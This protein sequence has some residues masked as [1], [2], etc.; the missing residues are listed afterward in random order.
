[1]CLI[2]MTLSVT[3]FGGIS[4]H[5]AT[6]DNG[7]ILYCPCMGLNLMYTLSI[8][9]IYFNLLGPTCLIHCSLKLSHV[10][11]GEE[12]RDRLKVLISI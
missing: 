10:S 1:V 7:Y 3:S 6:D 2:V 5:V 4:P 12:K 11:D 8:T 9:F